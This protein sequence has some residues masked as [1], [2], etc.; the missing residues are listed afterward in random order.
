MRTIDIEKTITISN[1]NFHLLNRYLANIPMFIG[2]C[3]SVILSN[4]LASHLFSTFREPYMKFMKGSTLNSLISEN[5]NM[6]ILYLIFIIIN[7]I[8][9]TAFFLKKPIMILHVSN[10]IKNK[11][12]TWCLRLFFILIGFGAIYCYYFFIH[13]EPTCTTG[14]YSAIFKS[15]ENNFIMHTII[16]GGLQIG[17][18]FLILPFIMFPMFCRK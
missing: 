12:K 15:H 1:M 8:S 5:A 7:I 9:I 18:Y 11:F 16:F 14:C 13:D 4:P 3:V 17:I 10:S 6:G 2:F